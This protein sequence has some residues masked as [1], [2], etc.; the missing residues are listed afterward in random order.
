MF[1]ILFFIYFFFDWVWQDNLGYIPKLVFLSYKEQPTQLK[2]CFVG[3]FKFYFHLINRLGIFLSKA[4][5]SFI[6]EIQI[7]L[8]RVF[9]WD[10]SQNLN[11]GTLIQ[12]WKSPYMLVFI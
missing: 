9:V 6:M 11:K 10:I 3:Y 4:A 8:G 1:L 2:F 7:S 12:I 5:I